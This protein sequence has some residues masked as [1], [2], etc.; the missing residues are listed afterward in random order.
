MK[1]KKYIFHLLCLNLAQERYHVELLCVYRGSGTGMSD[2]FSSPDPT[3]VFSA[4]GSGISRSNSRNDSNQQFR[5]LVPYSF[6]SCYPA[7][8]ISIFWIHFT[9]FVILAAK[10]SISFYRMLSSLILVQYL[11]RDPH[12]HQSPPLTSLE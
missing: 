4:S 2:S 3:M 6:L 10:S 8:K 5:L 12:L 1:I 11:H 7:A 9:I